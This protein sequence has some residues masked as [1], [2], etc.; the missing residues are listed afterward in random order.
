MEVSLFGCEFSRHPEGLS[1]SG[2]SFRDTPGS[3][4]S[5]L[6]SKFSRSE[7]SRHPFDQH[8]SDKPEKILKYIASFWRL[9]M[10]IA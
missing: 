4:F 10:N 1:F 8:H 9:P 7:I 5:G 3:E 6:G 2:L